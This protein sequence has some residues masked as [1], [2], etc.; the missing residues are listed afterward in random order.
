MSR[1]Y[2]HHNIAP[3][4]VKASESGAGLML[5]LNARRVCDRVGSKNRKLLKVQ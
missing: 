1:S 2:G 4:G 3:A 5:E